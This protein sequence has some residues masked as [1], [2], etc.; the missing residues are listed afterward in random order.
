MLRRWVRWS[1]H[2]PRLVAW[3]CLWLLILGGL[4]ASSLQMDLLPD[5]APAQATIETEAPGLV[6]EQV[7]ETVTSPIESV[8]LGAPGVAA[9]ESRSTQGLSVITVRFTAG[10]DAA[11]VR[12]EL[13]D[14]LAHVGD[15]PPAASAPR[16]SPPTAP[17]QDVRVIGFTSAKL[18]PMDLRDLVQ[19]TLRPRL[20]STKGVANV[21]IYGGQIR[22]IEVQAR[23][24]D[25]ADSDLGFLD[26]V[27]ATKRATS[28]AG[29]GFID[30]PNQRVLIEPQ[31]QAETLDAIKD[32]Q[33]QTPGNVP[34]RIDDVADVV[35][36]PAPAFG[37][38]LI[39]GKPG[40]EVVISRAPGAGMVET[41]RAID[42]TLAQLTPSLAAQGV[43]V[44]PDLDRPAGFIE[45]TTWD[46]VRDLLIGL[47]LVAVAL[48]IFMRDIRVVLIALAAVPLTLVAS[49]VVLKATGWTLNA[50]TLG[51]LAVALG[52]VIDDAVVDVESIVSDLRDAE[53]RHASRLDAIL[54]ASLEVRAPV[55]YATVALALSLAP[56][57][58]L[59]G[60]ARTLLEPLAT[61]IIV[62]SVASLL[63]AVV[64]TPA[65]AVMFLQHIKPEGEHRLV[66]GAK[67]A[68]SRW[69]ARERPWPVLIVAAV[70]GLIAVVA[71]GFFHTELL[72][73]VHD[74]HLVI[75]TDAP[76]ATSLDAVRASGAAVS[77]DLA[78]LPGV[79][80]VSE[81]I[82]R[83]AT[84]SEGA[85]IEH[86]VFDVALTPGLS[87]AAQADLARRIRARLVDYAGGAPVIRSGFD[88]SH[89]GAGVTAL[90]I[91][92]FGQ[93]LD[94][95]DRT[96]AQVRQALAALPGK[97]AVAAPADARGPVVRAD[98]DFNKLAL[99]G[100]SSSDVLDTIQAAF[101][102]ET[103]A[104]IY[105]GPRVV[106]LAVSAQADLRR[107]PESVGD[108]LLRSTT[109]FAVPL[110]SVANVY[111]TDGRAEIAHAGGLR[112]DLVEASPRGGGDI[113]RFA[114]EARAAI[115]HRVTLPAGVFL[116]VQ[117]VNSAAEA[118]RD[119]ALAY[120]LGLF[121]V[122]AF[123]TLAFDGRTA[124]LVLGS[125]AFGLIGGVIAV[126]ALGGV[127][128]IGEMAGLAA[129]T[130]LSMR[131]AIVVISRAEEL[132]A[133]A[134]APWSLATVSRAA[135][136]RLVPTL[137][138][139]ALIA[140]A[141]APFAFDA[142][143]PGHEIVGP[144]AIVILGG[145]V[146]SA[147]GAL[148]VLPPLVLRFWRPVKRLP[149]H[150][151]PPPT[152]S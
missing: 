30:T 55:L 106:D 130:G 60:E 39:D 122:F 57:L 69:L 27:N 149:V 142:G 96:A 134:D 129:L 124:V 123:L 44:H 111:L 83:D 137:A 9:V 131:S 42:A 151:P 68:Q 64:V 6:A 78:A 5:L 121:A 36:A 17:G 14:D 23:P 73:S 21:A 103:V 1:L 114:T 143:A 29:A 51:G 75:A 85:G 120:A 11:R 79:R 71:L 115:Q 7:E 90:R 38:A 46:Y 13:T 88:A 132:A 148:L 65:L 45:D 72:P 82:G 107:D 125:A 140:L 66:Q 92:V 16:L 145:V 100:L 93:D 34:A 67:R 127:L 146:T 135:G 108:L 59:P 81:R 19:W 40:V 63:V 101:A 28:I 113:D 86:G 102:G 84:A 22:R 10:A 126:A 48:L 105:E 62:A 54:A 141:L 118:G 50:M 97:P 56:M 98:L 53:T 58:L 91:N 80:G 2:R 31:G 43:A 8:L 4:Y 112:S 15:L 18:S 52:L 104:H 76:A 116:D 32:A 150:T 49:L 41:S 47:A 119:L 89:A 110:R 128:S 117:T 77:A 139:A 94:A 136:E 99:D 133:R 87:D 61:M 152:P 12:A 95:D 20:L 35:E 138:A 37:D 70:V 24:G 144:M 74:N 33:I 109:G 26:I 3:A 147:L 25:L